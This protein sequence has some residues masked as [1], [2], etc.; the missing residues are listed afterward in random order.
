M[1]DFWK[2]PPSYTIGEVVDLVTDWAEA[3]QAGRPDRKW[4]AENGAFLPRREWLHDRIGNALEQAIAGDQLALND[5]GTILEGDFVAWAIKAGIPV[6][7]EYGA[8][9]DNQACNGDA[10]KA[11]QRRFLGDDP[12]AKVSREVIVDYLQSEKFATS[13]REATRMWNALPAGIKHVGRPPG[14]KKT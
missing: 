8:P 7:S 13:K 9:S 1:S 10:L 3:A 6:P 12:D 11:I 4:V 5:D 2:V 14:Q